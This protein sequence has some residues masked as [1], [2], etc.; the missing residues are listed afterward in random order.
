MKFNISNDTVTYIS[1]YSIPYGIYHFKWYCAYIPVYP[2][3]LN[4]CNRLK[5]KSQKTPKKNDQTSAVIIKR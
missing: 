4:P 2:M 5:F 3:E 1:I